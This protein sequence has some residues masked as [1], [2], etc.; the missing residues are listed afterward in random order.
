MVLRPTSLEHVY[1][2]LDLYPCSGGDCDRLLSK[3]TQSMCER[4]GME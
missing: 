1:R 2:E 3:N 4:L